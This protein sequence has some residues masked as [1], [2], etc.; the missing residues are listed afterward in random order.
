VLLPAF[1]LYMTRYQIV[2]EERA[3]SDRFG[4]DY[5]DYVA[6]VRRWL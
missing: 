4:A 2:P 1:V 5:A 3:L 6:S